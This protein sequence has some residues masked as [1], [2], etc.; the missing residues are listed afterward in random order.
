MQGKSTIEKYFMYLKAIWAQESKG[1]G[2]TIAK[3]TKSFGIKPCSGC[4]RRRKKFNEAIEY[5]KKMKN[6]ESK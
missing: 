5:R 2:D 4:E 1:L 6:K 3:I